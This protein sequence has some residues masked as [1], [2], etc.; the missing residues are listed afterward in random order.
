MSDRNIKSQIQSA[1]G[2]IARGKAYANRNAAAALVQAANN[3]RQVIA[4]DRPN[5]APGKPSGR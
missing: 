3:A 2:V 1:N 5:K 4:H